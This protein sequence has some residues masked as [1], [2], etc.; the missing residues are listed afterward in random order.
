M[1]STGPEMF[2]EIVTTFEIEEPSD[3]SLLGD[4]FDYNLKSIYYDLILASPSEDPLNVGL[5][6]GSDILTEAASEDAEVCRIYNFSLPIR[7]LTYTN[8]E[9]NLDRISQ[10]I[11]NAKDQDSLCKSGCWSKIN[12]NCVII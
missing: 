2:T 5:S 4:Y 1:S 7:D 6:Y 9:V 11:Q 10:I 8:L 12:K 3:N